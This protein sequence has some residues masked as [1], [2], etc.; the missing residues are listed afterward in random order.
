MKWSEVSY[1]DSFYIPFDENQ[2]AIRG[3]WLT[4]LGI[5]LNSLPEIF[6]NEQFS[7]YEG[8]KPVSYSEEKVCLPSIVGTS[9][10]DY[11]G[12]AIIESYL[13]I[14]RA[15]HY[16][17]DGLVTRGKYFHS[18]KKQI[19]D[20]QIPVI[21][22]RNQDGTYFVDGNGNHRIILYKMMMYAEIGIKYP[23]AYIHR[24]DFNNCKTLSNITN[25]YWLN[26]RVNNAAMVTA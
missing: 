10:K 25:K 19:A 14:K 18:L 6:F 20:Q 26:A 9:Y 1:G 3:F 2:R 5:D 8:Q 17:N 7:F 13:K 16:I 21:L 22:S 12:S 23:N 24:P 11:G 4:T 15:C